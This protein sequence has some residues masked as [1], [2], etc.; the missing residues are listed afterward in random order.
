[1][2]GRRTLL[3]ATALAALAAAPAGA[4][5]QSNAAATQAY[6]KADL[7]MVQTAAAHLSTAESGIKRALA[8]V[9]STCPHAAGAGPQNPQ[10]TELSNETIGAIVLA[11]IHQDLASLRRF[12]AATAGLRWSNSALTHTVASYVS[13]LK[14][15]IALPEPPLCADVQG[16]ATSGFHTVP[17]RAVSFQ[18]R[19]MAAWVAIGELPTGGLLRY[20]SGEVNSL[21][22]RATA[23]EHRIEDFEARA[24]EK[25]ESIMNTLELSP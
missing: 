18:Q 17:A 10:S 6:V 15:M 24:V 16:W 13:R 7:A 2:P 11:A 25:W 21:A 1:M 4:A 19:F 9:R 14:A 8:T 22:R 23:L 5:A 3:L 20:E 12:V